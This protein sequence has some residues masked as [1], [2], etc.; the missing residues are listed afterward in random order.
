[1]IRIIA[2]GR[3]KDRWLQDG[4]AE[5]AK[6]IRPYDRLELI[7]VQDEMAPEKNSAAENEQ[8]KKIEG[9]RLLKQIHPQEYVIL[10]DLAD[11]GGSIV[12]DIAG[13]ERTDMTPEKLLKVFHQQGISNDRIELS[14]E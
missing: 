10:L 2:C 12:L 1:M 4:I 14:A 6:R 9:Q 5:Y 8:V 13:Q 3:V 7:E 11:W